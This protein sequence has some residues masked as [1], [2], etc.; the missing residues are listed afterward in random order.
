MISTSPY[1]VGNITALIITFIVVLSLI[2]FIPFAKAEQFF[3]L[4]GCGVAATRT[5]LE[6]KALTVYNIA[7]KGSA[8]GTIGDESFHEL[9][10]EFMILLRA[11]GGNAVGRGYYKFTFPDS[12][13]FVLEATDTLLEGSTWHMLHGAGKWAGIRGKGNGRFVIR[14]KPQ[15]IETEQYWFRIYGMLELPR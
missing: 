15:P 10:W 1:S 5:L 8:C 6:C 4:M 14:G 3:N 11:M 2:I 7:G 9:T 12:D 13:Y